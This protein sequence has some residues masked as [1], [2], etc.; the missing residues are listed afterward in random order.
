MPLLYDQGAPPDQG[1]A[2]LVAPGGPQASPP[3]P[4]PG[5]QPGPAPQPE[6]APQFQAPAAPTKTEQMLAGQLHQLRQEV[7]QLTSVVMQLMQR[8]MV[9]M[10]TTTRRDDSGRIT[11]LTMVGKLV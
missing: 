9:Q 6:P 4:V 2:G 5:G 11:G 8:E 3:Q 7:A 1:Q 10:D